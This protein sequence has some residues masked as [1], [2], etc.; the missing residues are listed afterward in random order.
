MEDLQ[1]VQLYWDRNQDAILATSAKYGNYCHSI[2]RNILGNLEDAEECVNDTYLKAWAAMPPHRPK[3]LGAFLGKITRNLSINRYK[4]DTANKRGSGKAAIV[5]DELKDIVSDSDSVE[6]IVDRKELIKAI[7][8]FLD[9]LSPD[10][11]GIFI[12][13]YWYFDSVADI[14]VRFGKTKGSVSVI[15]NRLRSKLRNHLT[16]RGFEV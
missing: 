5:L 3:L 10:K 12:C 9:K 7:N 15:L 11:R 2:A 16:E 8:A 6:Q 14:A 1:I 4:H 13:R